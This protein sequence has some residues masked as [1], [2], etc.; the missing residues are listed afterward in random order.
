[1]LQMFASIVSGPREHFTYPSLLGHRLLGGSFGR[2]WVLLSA[3][4]LRKSRSLK[5]GMHSHGEDP[6]W[7]CGDPAFWFLKPDTLGHLVLLGPSGW[8]QQQRE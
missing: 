5:G 3:L 8:P 6:V 7:G 2:G 4:G 1:M